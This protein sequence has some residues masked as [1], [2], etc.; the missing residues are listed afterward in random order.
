[1][2]C[3]W[4][5]ARWPQLSRAATLPPLAQRRQIGVPP[6]RMG[7]AITGLLHGSTLYSVG[8]CLML[9]LSKPREIGAS[10]VA[11]T[12]VLPRW[13]MTVVYPAL[14]STEF[15]AGFRA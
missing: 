13:D 1:M 11:T 6:A 3:T 12:A 5:T 4:C 15:D 7:C 8:V 14:D 10:P 9:Y 2:N